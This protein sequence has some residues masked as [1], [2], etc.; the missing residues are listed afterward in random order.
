MGTLILSRE[1]PINSLCVSLPLFSDRIRNRYRV[2]TIVE[3]GFD[4]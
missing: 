3:L 2:W 4:V 1:F